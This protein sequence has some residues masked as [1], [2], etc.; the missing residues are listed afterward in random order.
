MINVPPIILKMLRI[1]RKARLK[2]KEMR[3]LLLYG[4]VCTSHKF[5]ALTKYV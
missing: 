3:V 2:D 1:L 5:G 4:G